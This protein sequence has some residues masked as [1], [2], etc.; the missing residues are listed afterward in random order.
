MHTDLKTESDRLL[1]SIVETVIQQAAARGQEFELA[2]LYCSVPRWFDAE[3]VAGM[4]VSGSAATAST[5]EKLQYLRSLP[6]CKS[7]P[8]RDE[9]WIFEEDFRAHL[10]KRKEVAAAWIELQ[11]RAV[12]IFKRRSET[13]SREGE[14]RLRDPD[15]KN[16]AVEYIY[17]LQ[18]L[19]SLKAINVVR[20]ICAEALAVWTSGG[21]RPEVA[22]CLDFLARL[23]W[24]V[25]AE[26]V[27]KINILKS[28]M[29]ALA[30]YDDEKALG[31]LYDLAGIRELTTKQEGA[32]RYWIGATHLRNE[33]RVA[34][35]LQQLEKALQLES[36]NAAVH[37]ELAAAY[38]WPGLLWGRLD[39]AQ[40]H[41]REAEGPD[42]V[43][44]YLASARIAEL[45]EAYDEA[46]AWCQKA[47]QAEPTLFNG[48]LSLSELYVARG[49]LDKALDAID[50][51]VRLSPDIQYYALIRRGNAYRNARCYRE[52]LNEYRQ[53]VN[54]N[55]DSID[56]YLSSGELHAGRWQTAEA[57]QL[58]RKALDLNPS[59]A[60]SYV[61]LARLYVQT[62]RQEQLLAICQQAKDA[63]IDS[64]DLLFMLLDSYRFSDRTSELRQV[65]KQLTRLDAAEEYPQHCEMGDDWLAKAEPRHEQRWLRKA[66]NE[67]ERAR[68]I[69][70]HRAWAYISMI[71]LAVVR[72]DADKVQWQ[73]GLI[74]ER[75]PW[76]QNEML[77]ALGTAYLKNF[78]YAEAEKALFE[79]TELYAHREAAWQALSDLYY[80]QGD[81]SGVVRAWSRLVD[82]NPIL[83]YDSYINIGSAYQAVSDYDRAREQY[84][85]AKELEPD[86][87]DAYLALAEL[88]YVQNRFDDAIANYRMVE[89]KA[90]GRAPLI[91]LRI[92]S[93]LRNQ[94]AYDEA[95]KAI[96]TA[97]LLNKEM[98]E[99]FIELARLGVVQRRQELI[100]EGKRRLTAVAADKLYDLNNAIG[101]QYLKSGDYENAELAYRECKR[102]NPNRPDSFVALGLLRISQE[103]YRD[104]KRWFSRALKIDPTS[105]DAYSGLCQVHEIEKN[106]RAFVETQNRMVEFNPIERF[107]SRRAVAMMHEAMGELDEAEQHLRTA[108][109]LSPWVAGA[110][111]DLGSLLRRRGKLDEAQSAYGEARQAAAISYVDLGSYYEEQGKPDDALEVYRLGLNYESFE[112]KPD[113]Y[114]ALASLQSKQDNSEQ[115]KEGYEEAL[116]L[117]PTRRGAYVNLAELLAK[118]NRIDEALEVYRQMA[119][120]PELAGPAHI[121]IGN[122]LVLQHKYEEGAQL[123]REAIEID[124]TKVDPYL[125][126]AALCLQQDKKDEVEQLVLRASEAAPNDPEP[127]RLLAELRERQRRSEDAIC[128]YR[129]AV[130]LESGGVAASDAFVRIGNLLRAQKR[131]DEAQ[132]EFQHAIQ[133]DPTNAEAY[134][135]LGAVYEQQDNVDRA[136]QLYRQVVEFQ[137]TGIAASQAYVRIGNLLRAR[138]QYDQA[139]QEFQHAIQSSPNNPGAYYDLATIYEQQGNTKKALTNYI[140]ATDLAPK[141]RDAYVGRGRIYAK[142]KDMKSVARMARQILDLELDPAEKYDA[143]LLIADVYKAA[144]DADQAAHS[145]RK[146]L[147]L[148]PKHPEAYVSLAQLLAVE[149]RLEEA[150]EIWRQMAS[151]PE[152]ARTA[153]ISIGNLLATRKKFE[154]AEQSYRRAIEV[155]PKESEAYLGL[156]LVYQ[157]QGKLDDMERVLN[158][159][160]IAV[161]ND[162]QVYRLQAQLRQEQGRPDEAITLYRRIVELQPSNGGWSEAYEQIGSLMFKRKRYDEAEDALL[163]AAQIDPGNPAIH[164]GLGA[165]YEAQEQ[166][167]RA[168]GSYKKATEIDPKYG[169][170]Y[171]AL[172]HIYAKK[173]DTKGLAQMARRILELDLSPTD[174][175]EAHLM[176]GNAYQ[177]AELY[178]WAI[179]HLN[180][181][182]SLDPERLEAYTALGLIYEIQQLWG[183]AGDIY[184][185]VGQLNPESEPDVHFRLGQ[186]YLLEQKPEEAE[187]EFEQ[188][189]A[190]ILAVNDERVELLRTAYLLIASIYRKN[191]K[192]EGM[193]RACAEVLSQLQSNHSQDQNALR[194]EGLARLMLGQ[195]EAAT[196]ALRKA[197]ESNEADTKARLYLAVSL[198]PL[199]EAEEAQLHLKKAIQ[200]I[201]LREDYDVAIAEAEALVTRV[202]EVAGAK[203][204]LQELREASDKAVSSVATQA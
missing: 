153:F 151:Q 78:Q 199:N 161:P 146:A 88:D 107:N 160:L 103:R 39:L 8:T 75:A 62:R 94:S 175:Y 71:K 99:A 198:L 96:R 38:Y 196:D 81:V 64:K 117:D 120:V 40:Q 25:S 51:A 74:K 67:Y 171:R 23:D 63:G 91:H 10:V 193:K 82:I 102:R 4:L 69:D 77:V 202:P 167:E 18:Y 194:H 176:I 114:I 156:G 60:R 90:S 154:D 108:I 184:R 162:P 187:Q 195:Y 44:G 66:E 201:K 104:A 42:E 58:Y 9:T 22:F 37:A 158:E 20:Q 145:Y 141:Y 89:N 76:A 87:S 86:T 122:L 29:N 129:K 57:E 35:A 93:I 157:R 54:E 147:E 138:K 50:K 149:N 45:Q 61:S 197:L 49:D 132:Q 30:I 36:N 142:R 43:S 200:H 191:G 2:L 128:E 16:F 109:G 72:G 185:R 148:Y 165:V 126:L 130:E 110:Y 79:A 186:L 123:Y 173:G 140:Q 188:V 80:Q 53:A 181:A 26:K 150:L 70:P 28:G 85:H 11:S 155:E 144:G 7:H 143:Y 111:A 31:M 116:R 182:V 192:L 113:L 105:V 121:S 180:K 5:E 73:K 190:R 32:L 27:I 164:F 84:A 135:N 106:L 3:V 56:A 159:A 163:M 170:A 119:K 52:A 127:H 95:E 115:A 183:K 139:A 179:D 169:D 92:A 178:E 46:I 133:S 33:G 137:S 118:E 1:E 177:E 189:K 15:A 101:D 134:Y 6:F 55:P 166:V 48:Y 12:E 100:E 152:L 204:L 19:D 41:A 124:P 174:Q 17:H 98:A 14:K 68:E 112:H 136:V 83:I 97:I 125:E 21:G 65:R 168:L 203:N 131:Y 34:P 24:S 47:I 13:K 59:G 172:G